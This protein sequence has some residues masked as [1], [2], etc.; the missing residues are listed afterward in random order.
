MKL[1]SDPPQ[2]YHVHPSEYSTNPWSITA[3]SVATDSNLSRGDSSEGTHCPAVSYRFRPKVCSRPLPS[4]IIGFVLEK[5]LM[6]LMTGM[7]PTGFPTFCSYRYINA[8]NDATN[9]QFILPRM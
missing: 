5:G 1:W 9:S 2:L 3:S 6:D 4:M 7:M 8:S